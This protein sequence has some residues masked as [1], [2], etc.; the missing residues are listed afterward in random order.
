MLGGHLGPLYIRLAPRATFHSASRCPRASRRWTP[1]SPRSIGCDPD[2]ASAAHFDAIFDTR[3][4]LRCRPCTMWFCAVQHHKCHL[5]YCPPTPCKTN[6]HDRQP[7]LPPRCFAQHFRNAA[8]IGCGARCDDDDTLPSPLRPELS[9]LPQS[10]TAPCPDRSLS[11]TEQPLPQPHS[12]RRRDI[13]ID[14]CRR[15]KRECHRPR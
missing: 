1:R 9:E 8:A 10:H 5:Q 11:D 15:L 3:H 7:R 6:T 12:T 13:A 2:W 14:A 4:R